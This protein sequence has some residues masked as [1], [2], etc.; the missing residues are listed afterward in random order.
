MKMVDR[1]QLYSAYDAVKLAVQSGCGS[2]ETGQKIID[3]AVIALRFLNE[4][5][6]PVSLQSKVSG[7]EYISFSRNGVLARP[8]NLAYFTN[9]PDEIVGYWQHW[10]SGGNLDAD[11][12]ARMLYTVALA[13]CLS[14][15]LFNRNDKKRPAT[16]F[17]CMVGHIFAK[18]MSIEPIKSATLPVSGGF[19]RMTMD[20][21][22]ETAGDSPNIHLPVKM[23]TR[24]RVVQAWAHQRMLD[25][26]YGAGSYQGILVVFSETK[27]DVRKR[28]V[29]EIC[30]PDQWLAYQSLLAKMEIIYYFDITVR[31][32]E[33]TDTFPSTISIR[34]FHSFLLQ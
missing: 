21:L 31:Y 6:E 30:V 2:N 17:E 27:L 12:W 15:D 33:L 8:A 25:S 34:P 23:S 5:C 19:A 22:F 1:V 18:S 28:E 16:Y 14:F 26:A 29:V 7:K 32:Q 13:P 4:D 24:E 11:R 10:A 9:S 3:V 20:F